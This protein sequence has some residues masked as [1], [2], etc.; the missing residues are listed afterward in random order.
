M[1]HR[2]YIHTI[3]GLRA[4]NKDLRDRLFQSKA[5]PPSGINL[6]E[7]YEA[8]QEREKAQRENPKP[9]ALGPIEQL[10]KRWTEDDRNKADRLNIDA[11]KPRNLVN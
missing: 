8:K 5:M 2:A 3:D 9:K 6:T 4:D 7:K 10:E 1:I 11:T